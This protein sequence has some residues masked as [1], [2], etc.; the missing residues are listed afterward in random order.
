MSRIPDALNGFT[1][2]LRR[3]LATGQLAARRQ[4]LVCAEQAATLG[5]LGIPRTET[6]LPGPV[7][8]WETALPFVTRYCGF[9]GPTFAR[10]ELDR[11]CGMPAQSISYKVGE[12]VWLIF[13]RSC[14]RRSARRST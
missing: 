3:G 7:W 1:T 12:R 4:A 6:Y 13:G 11:Y 5:G 8:D 10:S 2:S 14:G 9:A